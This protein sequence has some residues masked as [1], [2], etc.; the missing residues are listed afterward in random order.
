MGRASDI[1]I[2]ARFLLTVGHFVTIVLAFYQVV[3][4]ACELVMTKTLAASLP[5][6]RMPTSK[7]VSLYLPVIHLRV[8]QNK[9]CKE[10]SGAQ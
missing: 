7:R 3:G 1:L 6:C 9:A 2:P 5:V 8:L 10:R 4:T